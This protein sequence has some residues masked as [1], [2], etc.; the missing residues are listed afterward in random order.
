MICKVLGTIRAYQML[1]GVSSVCVGVSGGA[2]SVALLHVLLQIRPMF[3]YKLF[4]V[5]VNHHLRGKEAQR[6]AEFV[7]ALC[8][9]WDVPCRIV[10]RDVAALSEK[11]KRSLEVCGR[12]V[13]YAAFAAENCDAIAV[14]HTRSDSIETSLFHLARGTSLKGACGIPPKNGRV[15]RPLIECSR[16]EIESYLRENHIDYV[17]DST[18]LAN[19]FSRN[20]IRNEIMK[21]FKDRFP[22][23]E[24]SYARYMRN[25]A[26]A[27]SY[28]E[29]SA[30]ELLNRAKTDDGFAL[31]PLQ[32]AHPAVLQCAVHLILSESM[33]KQAEAEHVA[34]CCDAVA[35]GQGKIEIASNLFFCV[36]KGS[37]QVISPV[38][39]VEWKAPLAAFPASAD[40]P[41][42]VY[43]VDLYRGDQR[44]SF[45]RRHWIDPEKLSGTLCFRS[46]LPGDV[47]RSPIR[48]QSKSLKKLFNEMKLSQQ[49]RASCAILAVDDKS[50][51]IVWLEHVGVDAAFQADIN[52]DPVWIVSKERNSETNA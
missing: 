18:N 8:E 33:N 42:G 37:V 31:M 7:R 39:T 15:I 21:P 11:T 2:D 24:A 41:S 34:L 43:H 30:L 22:S 50:Q 47:F 20:F 26:T 17:V 14:A 27:Q 38:K 1:E 49:A 40:C 25:A 9:K 6:D 10:D 3:G 51:K 19:A 5:H 13:R 45:D 36:S 35:A 12:E 28:L 32:N 48:K 46:R 29:S 52:T 23:F 44:L 4:A 16:A